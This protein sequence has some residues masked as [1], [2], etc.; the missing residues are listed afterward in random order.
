MWTLFAGCCLLVVSI[1][2][3]LGHAYLEIGILSYYVVYAGALVSFMVWNTKRDK[4]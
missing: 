4:K 3:V 1:L 2:Y